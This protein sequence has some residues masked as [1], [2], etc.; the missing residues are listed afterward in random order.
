MIM[1]VYN[2][3]NQTRLT[4]VKTRSKICLFWASKQKNSL[5]MGNKIFPQNLARGRQKKINWTP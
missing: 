2:K 3:F 5:I 4:I 1:L